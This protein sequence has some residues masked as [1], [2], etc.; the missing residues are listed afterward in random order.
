MQ[1]SKAKGYC[2]TR[3]HV[4]ATNVEPCPILF[5][6]WCRFGIIFRVQSGT[7][8]THWPELLTPSVRGGNVFDATLPRHRIDGHPETDGL[9]SINNIVRLIL[10]PGSCH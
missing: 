6:V 5:N 7:I 3:L 2:I 1:S 8:K 9:L 10:M 4:P